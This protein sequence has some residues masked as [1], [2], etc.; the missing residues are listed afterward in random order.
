MIDYNKIISLAMEDGASIEDIAKGLSDALNEAQ[1]PKKSP[2]EVYL[3]KLNDTITV[4]LESESFDVESA[5][6][7]LVTCVVEKHPEWSVDAI[8]ALHKA[9]IHSV[10]TNEKLVDCVDKGG[11]FLD[12]ILTCLEEAVSEKSENKSKSKKDCNCGRAHRSDDETLAHFLR[13]L[14]L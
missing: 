2:R 5:L 9:L 3:E 14:G 13:G 7:L 12:T 8:E 4:A 6:A 10:E 11:D 1:K